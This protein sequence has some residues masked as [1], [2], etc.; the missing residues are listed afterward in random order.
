VPHTFGTL[1]IP[2]ALALVAGGLFLVE[3][4]MADPLGA[5]TESVLLGSVV[6]ASGLLLVAYLLRSVRI[7]AMAK[8]SEK[9]PEVFEPK[10]LAVVRRSSASNAISVPAHPLERAYVDHVRISL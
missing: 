10:R 9:N 6:L 4:P 5:G 3:R 7:A 1:L 8:R 2:L